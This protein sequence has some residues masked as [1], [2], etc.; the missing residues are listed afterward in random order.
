MQA[1]DEGAGAMGEDFQA[2][3]VPLTAAVAVVDLAGAAAS[4]VVLPGTL[5]EAV[6]ILSR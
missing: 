4:V 6:R 1:E 2:A 5:E 3:A